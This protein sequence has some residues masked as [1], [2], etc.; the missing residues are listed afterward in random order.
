MLLDMGRDQLAQI[1]H[2]RNWDHWKSNFRNP[3]DLL[4]SA[5]EYLKTSEDVNISVNWRA[6]GDDPSAL[7]VLLLPREMW[8]SGD[9]TAHN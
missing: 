8:R 9:A 6:L 1:C 7:R 5:E 4:H 2:Y 3:E